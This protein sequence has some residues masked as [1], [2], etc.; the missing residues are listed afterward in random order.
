MKAPDWSLRLSA[1]TSSRPP[2][3]T[4][5]FSQEVPD[6]GLVQSVLFVKELGHRLRS[7]LQQLVLHQVDH[8]LR[9]VRNSAL[10]IPGMNWSISIFSF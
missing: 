6:G 5:P 7:P 8:A 10:W 3:C 4:V 9:N 1:M 2:R